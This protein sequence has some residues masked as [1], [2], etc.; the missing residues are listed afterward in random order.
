[1]ALIFCDGPSTYD[2]LHV[3]N[4]Y[5]IAFGTFSVNT[6]GGRNNR[7]YLSNRFGEVRKVYQ[8]STQWLSTYR[9]GFAYSSI[10]QNTG[11]A[12]QMYVGRQ[13]DGIHVVDIITLQVLADYTLGLFV[14]TV[15]VCNTTR[16]AL[17]DQSQ[18]P[19]PC[20]MYYELTVEIETLQTGHPGVFTIFAAGEIRMNSQ[21]VTP[22][23]GALI[24]SGI[25]TSGTP[26]M[27]PSVNDHQLPIS[28]WSSDIYIS[29]QN[30]KFSGY[31]NDPAINSTFANSDGSEAMWSGNFS[32]INGF[33]P[34]D[35]GT[36]GLDGSSVTSIY[37]NFF[38]NPLSLAFV[39]TIHAIMLWAY[40][41][42]DS[43]TDF[44][45][46]YLGDPHA[47]STS[48]LLPGT[49]AFFYYGFGFD[50]NF[51]PAVNSPWT[52]ANFNAEAIGFQMHT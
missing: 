33:P 3:P 51:D 4:K 28:C 27:V 36:G 32:N 37:S 26:L 49:G 14:G 25:V 29:D 39:G 13:N 44:L 42:S 2:T 8:L 48:A 38:F 45:F 21:L 1:M 31:G 10:Q 20:W 43:G 18:L 41:V 34:S 30:G 19:Y 17:R 24:D 46:G 52:P 7:P 22:A 23:A 9:V 15:L 6:S 47:I 50:W 35:L 11:N 40:A 12:S 16:T 5:D